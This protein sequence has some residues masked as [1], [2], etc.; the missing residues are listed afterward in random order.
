MAAQ[1]SRDPRRRHA[2]LG[3]VGA[4]LRRVRRGGGAGGAR[5][6]RR[7][8]EGRPVRRRR[9]DDPQRL[10]RLRGRR[11]DRAGARLERRAGRRAATARARAAARPS[12]WRA[13]RSWR[14]SATSRS[15]SAPTPRRRASSRRPAAAT[16]RKDPD[17]LRFRLLGA[18]N[19]VYF[20]LYARRRM[21]LYGDTERDF[22]QV[23]VKNSRCGAAN[24]NARY[25]QTYTRRGGARLGDGLRPAA[26]APDLRHQRRRRGARA[27]EPGVRAAS[28]R[29]SPSRSRPSRRSRRASRRP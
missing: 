21:D 19:P 27:V 12:R 26:P 28:A 20:G 2:P 18:T 8:V 15:W 5:R 17:W 10:P 1:G 16:A 9:R 14:A 6:R 22:A 29:R 3:Q 4:Q 13:R 7:R 23:K 25:R 24:P 11:L